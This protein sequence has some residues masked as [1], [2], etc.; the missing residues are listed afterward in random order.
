MMRDFQDGE[1]TV[2]EPLLMYSSDFSQRRR[3]A[4][5][6]P[7]REIEECPRSCRSSPR[8]ACPMAEL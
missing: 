1:R 2:Y 6:V 4:V 8:R 7:S 3:R 5:R